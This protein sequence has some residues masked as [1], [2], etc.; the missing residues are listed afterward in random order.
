MQGNNISSVLAMEMP[1]SCNRPSTW[2]SAGT[3]S[4][5]KLQWLDLKHRARGH[6]PV[7]DTRV[8]CTFGYCN[9]LPLL[10][11]KH[12]ILY[13]FVRC[14]LRQLHLFHSNNCCWFITSARIL[15][16][17]WL[18]LNLFS[19]T[20]SIIARNIFGVNCHQLSLYNVARMI[21]DA[22]H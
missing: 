21:Y 11:K 3:L 17:A 19:F 2:R 4:W 16:L 5:K 14:L 12:P 13:Q 6:V 8:K 18:H 7:M 9:D 15:V 22:G 1:Q 20:Q 10:T